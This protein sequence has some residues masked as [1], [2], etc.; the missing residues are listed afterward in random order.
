M[1]KIYK[2]VIRIVNNWKYS[3]APMYTNFFSTL[4]THTV[5]QMMGVGG[6]RGSPQECYYWSECSNRCHMSGMA[7]TKGATTVYKHHVVSFTDSGI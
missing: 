4:S 2:H 1:T 7:K 5:K 3:L 6:P